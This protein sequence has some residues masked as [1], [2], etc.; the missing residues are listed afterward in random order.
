MY[1]YIKRK[2]DYE[3]LSKKDDRFYIE[4]YI[5]YESPYRYKKY[6]E[7]KF[8]YS[9]LFT[10]KS[11]VKGNLLF[12]H[13]MGDKNLKFLMYF[14][15]EFAKNGIRTL[16]T[17]LPYHFERTPKGMKSGEYILKENVL[18]NFE[19]SVVD[20]RYSLN[21]LRQ[22]GD[23]P[24][25][26]MGV[27]FGGMIATISMAFEKDVEKGILVVTGGNFYYIT[28]ESIVTK[29][30]RKSYE[31]DKTCSKK[32]CFKIHKNFR[33]FIDNLNSLDELDKK[34][35]I[36]DCFLYDPLTFAKFLKERKILMFGAKF[37]VFIPK[38]STLSL[39][40]ELGEPELV[41]FPTGHLSI[42]LLR[43]K[44]LNKSLKFLQDEDIY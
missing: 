7:T 24:L 16:V 5:K 6:E 8:I 25:S 15:K 39:W 32:K 10:P 26:I 28:W 3:I 42:I 34:K 41:W 38:E 2:I 31:E 33:D 29:V 44:I 14:P 17:I 22:L 12:L 43:K 4:E 18:K 1:K 40:R 27:S 35:P 37:D 30:L 13:G 19:F 9:Y 20:T 21:L 11:K 36:K 23:E